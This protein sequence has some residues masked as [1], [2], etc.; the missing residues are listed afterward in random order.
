MD[1]IF[2]GGDIDRIMAE[3]P[4]DGEKSGEESALLKQNNF[5]ELKITID[6]AKDG[7]EPEDKKPTGKVAFN[8]GKRER[9]LASA[10]T[11]EQV[12]MV[13]SLLKKDLSDCESGLANDMCDENEV[14]KVKAMLAK[15]EERMAQVSR[16]GNSEKQKGDNSFLINMLM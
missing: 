1:E 11:P 12:Q 4:Q 6:Q 5:D 2:A 7:E 8:Q 13:M 14:R 3:K 15:A 9:Q 16:E 10:K